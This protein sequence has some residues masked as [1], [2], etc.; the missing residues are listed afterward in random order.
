M[1]NLLKGFLLGVSTIIFIAGASWAMID[2]SS[3]VQSKQLINSINQIVT[4]YC[5]VYV[6]NPRTRFRN[7]GINE[8]M[9]GY[10]ESNG[11]RISCSK[12]QVDCFQKHQGHKR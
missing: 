11:D 8:V 3:P 10:S 12:L 7:C 5:S 6:G 4:S 9:T 2:D 1:K